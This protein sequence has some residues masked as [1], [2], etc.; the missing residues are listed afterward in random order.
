MD[1][2]SKNDRVKSE[3][4]N[5]KP[6]LVGV[7]KVSIIPFNTTIY[8]TVAQKADCSSQNSFVPDVSIQG[9]AM[10]DQPWINQNTTTPILNDLQL[11]V[12]KKSVFI[13]NLDMT[14]KNKRLANKLQKNANDTQLLLIILAFFL[15]PLAVYLYEGNIWTSRCTLNLVLTIL[16]GI[17]GII[18]ALIIILGGK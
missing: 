12:E 10:L 6:D 4:R 17:P 9:R 14:P 5:Q 2:V 13:S 7:E 3:H 11:P 16:C 8:P 18:H 15:P 1:W